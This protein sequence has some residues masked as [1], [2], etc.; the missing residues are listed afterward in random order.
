MGQKD[1]DRDAKFVK[2]WNQNLSQDVIAA[3]LGLQRK[4]LRTLRDRLGLAKREIDRR[5]IQ[6]WR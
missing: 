3:R 5:E 1:H 2:L 4:S 6:S